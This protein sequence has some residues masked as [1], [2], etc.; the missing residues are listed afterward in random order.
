VNSY[1]RTPSAVL[2]HF[3]AVAC[4]S[5]VIRY[6]VTDCSVE[7]HHAQGGAVRLPIARLRFSA[8]EL[9]GP[10]A[11]ILGISTIWGHVR[12]IGQLNS[13]WTSQP[14]TAVPPG[15]MPSPHRTLGDPQIPGDLPDLVPAGEPARGVQPQPLLPPGVYPASLRTPHTPVIRP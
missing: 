6:A 4:S 7:T 12:L 13:H 11:T 2:F 10:G 5:A 8:E 3:S 15:L 14:S 1:L 9:G